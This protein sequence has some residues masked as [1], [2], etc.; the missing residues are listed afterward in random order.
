MRGVWLFLILVL[1][2]GAATAAPIEAF[3]HLQSFEFPA[4]APD[5]SKFAFVTD[6]EGGRAIVV[7]ALDAKMTVLGIQKLNDEKLRGI[8]WAD[9]NRLLITQSQTWSTVNNIR[10][11]RQ[12]YFLVQSYDAVTHESHRLLERINK[13]MNV[14]AGPSEPRTVDGKTVV[15]MRGIAF[16]DEQGVYGLL[17]YDFDSNKSRVV[18]AG[19][20]YTEDWVV[21]ENGQVVAMSDYH[22]DTRV[23]RLLLR[24]NGGYVEAYRATAPIE[25]PVVEG[26]TPDGSSILISTND[27]GHWHDIEVR[28][29][30]GA[31]KT[32]VDLVGNDTDVLEDPTTHRIIGTLRVADTYQYKFFDPEEQ[33]HWDALMRAFKG[34]NV[35][36]RSWSADRKQIIIRV[37]GEQH[38]S[39]YFLVDLASLRAEF[40]A[41][42]YNDIQPADV[43]EVRVVSYKAADGTPIFGYLTLPKGHT[44][45]NLPLVVLPHGGPAARDMP[46]FDWWSQGIASAG[47]AVFQPQFRGSDGF[48][49]KFLS[50]GFGE[51]GRKMQTDLSDGVRYLAAA[52]TIDPKRVCIVG[53]SYG[54]YAAL[55]GPTLDKGVYRCAVSVAGISDLGD[56]LRWRARR[57]RSDDDRTQRYWDRFMDA[58]GPDDPKLKQISP[59]DHLDNVDV[60]ILLIHGRDDT[61]V[62][63]QQ[64]IEMADA[65]N[66]AHK[67]VTFIKLDG[68][69][70]WLSRPETRLQMLQATVKFLQENNPP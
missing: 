68:E 12:E 1:F 9:N 60:P 63:L 41:P 5:G 11:P 26:I 49:W 67:P 7:R 70:H 52:G 3:G 22:D 54:G 45:K 47:Y 15:Y 14:L 55:A 58:S 40:L 18:E 13:A 25:T 8:K 42:A 21:G 64:S 35:E 48:G 10:A 66:A 4:I 57:D 37:D 30:D 17:A 43:N 53:G 23:W 39:S 31:V 33:K 62:P 56:F 34:E 36:L 61:V 28:I 65:L 16:V 2:G 50:A 20:K 69:D 44:D 38:G 59:I 27:D 51:W 32:G 6:F 46:G 19:S 24:R 29:A